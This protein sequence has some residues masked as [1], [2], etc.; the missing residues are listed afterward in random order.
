MRGE[1]YYWYGTVYSLTLLTCNITGQPYNQLAILANAKGEQLETVYF[2]CRRLDIC[3][4]WSTDMFWVKFNSVLHRGYTGL[5]L[6]GG[7]DGVG[8]TL[9]INFIA[10]E[11]LL[12]YTVNASKIGSQQP[13]QYA[14]L[15]TA[16][17]KALGVTSFCWQVCVL[18]YSTCR[19]LP[20]PQL[21]LSASLY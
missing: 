11:I 17:A 19:L 6:V 21:Y 9:T 16:A 2:Y 10:A 1:N 7:W 20:L 3:S 15:S 13:K 12:W 14:L 5:F 8:I 18:P 4:C